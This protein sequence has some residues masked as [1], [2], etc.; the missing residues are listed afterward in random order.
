MLLILKLFSRRARLLLPTSTL[1]RSCPKRVVNGI[2]RFPKRETQRQIKRL[3]F[4]PNSMVGPRLALSKAKAPFLF[5][6]RVH[7]FLFEVSVSQLFS[8]SF[9]FSLSLSL[10]TKKKTIHTPPLALL[11]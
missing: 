1:T 11:F 10:K 5:P 6:A 2:G 4:F 9:V 8:F 3:H 7:R